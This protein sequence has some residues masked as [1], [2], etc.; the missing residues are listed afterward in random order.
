MVS[1]TVAI[2]IA[3]VPRPLHYKTCCSGKVKGRRDVLTI[4]VTSQP[5]V[6]HDRERPSGVRAKGKT[7]SFFLHA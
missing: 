4:S 2:S 1:G 7:C 5:N 3:S 6:L